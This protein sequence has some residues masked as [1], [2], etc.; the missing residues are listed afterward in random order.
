MLKRMGT[1]LSVM[2]GLL[3]AGAAPSVDAAESFRDKCLLCHT[4]RAVTPAQRAKL[5]GPPVDEVLLH[6]KEKYPIKEDA[7]NFMAD[8]ILHPTVEK[9]LCPSID[10]FGLM[11]SM[12]SRVEPAEARAL[13]SMLFDR[14]PQP[15]FLNRHSQPRFSDLD[16]DGDGFVTLDE[17]RRFRTRHGLHGDANALFAAADRNKDGK[18][19]P[20]EFEAL[21]RNS[22]HR[23]PRG[24]P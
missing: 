22:S 20:K 2:S 16:S 4:D 9:A 1:V 5:L 11:P 15:E 21:R 14:Y 8:Y 6:V 10:K 7:V 13:A 24:A 18:M 3:L 23:T 12:R 17:F 19:S